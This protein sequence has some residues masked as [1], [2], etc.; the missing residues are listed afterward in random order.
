MGDLGPGAD[1]H[2]HG[3]LTDRPAADRPRPR[4]TG[5]ASTVAPP[6][7]DSHHPRRA[8]HAPRRP[9][10]ARAPG[11]R[12]RARPVRHGTRTPVDRRPHRAM[13]GRAPTRDSGWT[14]SAVARLVARRRCVRPPLQWGAFAA[15]RRREHH[16]SPSPAALLRLSATA[17]RAADDGPSPRRPE[18]STADRQDRVPGSPSCSARPTMQLYLADRHSLAGRASSIAD[19]LPAS[20]PGPTARRRHRDDGC[21]GRDPSCGPTRRRTRQ[22][23]VACR[24]DRLACRRFDVKRMLPVDELARDE[25]FNRMRDRGGLRSAATPAPAAHQHAGADLRER[26]RQRPSADARHLRGRDPGARGRRPHLLGLRDRRRPGAGPVRAEA[27]HGPPVLGRGPPRRDLAASCSDHMG[28]R[29]RRVRRA[30][31]ALRGGLQPR[32]RAA[33]HRRQPGPRGPG[34]RRVQD[35]A[36]LRRP[37]HRSGAGVRRGLDAGRRGHPREDGLATGCAA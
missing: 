2:R 3:R 22:R 32:P 37:A 15:L 11:Q 8:D 5:A 26:Q 34:H 25:R 1:H 33:P 17:L 9:I 14:R 21:P 23:P 27:R 16:A 13:R 18:R 35:D 12:P 31:P 36:R 24:R 20:S 6:R 4:V 19:G 29:H 10:A 28:T 30:D 7:H